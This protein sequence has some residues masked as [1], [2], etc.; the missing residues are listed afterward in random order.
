MMKKELEENDSVSHPDLGFGE[1]MD[2]RYSLNGIPL[3]A[4]VLWDR[5]P[6]PDFSAGTNP[7]LVDM[8]NLTKDE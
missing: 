1:I 5:D 7:C 4:M 3:Y 8:I 6:S 2:I